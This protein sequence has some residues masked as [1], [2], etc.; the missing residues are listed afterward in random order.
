MRESLPVF[1]GPGS[2]QRGQAV[3]ELALIL[4]VLLVMMLGLFDMGRAFVFGVAVQNGA[5]EATRLGARSHL[6]N[7]PANMDTMILQRLID[8]S[9]PALSGCQAVTGTQ[10]ANGCSG[11]VFSLSPS[12]AKAAGSTLTITA[13]GHP[14]LFAGFVS[15]AM[16]LSMPQVTVQGQAVMEVL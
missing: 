15:G 14:S 16:G 13:V 3:V 9:S 8:A 2:R 12:G 6:L 4:P 1:N 5:R 11:W 7:D 10:P